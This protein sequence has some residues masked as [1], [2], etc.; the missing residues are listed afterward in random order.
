MNIHPW[1]DN[2]EGTHVAAV[3]DEGERLRYRD[4][5]LEMEALLTKNTER[6]ST[7]NQLVDFNVSPC[8]FQFNN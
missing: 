6:L 4:I 1:R 3:I 7:E 2:A 8:I 5:C